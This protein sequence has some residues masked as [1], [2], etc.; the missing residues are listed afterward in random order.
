MDSN[1]RESQVEIERDAVSVNQI[2][3][4]AMPVPSED[5]MQLDPEW[6]IAKAIEQKLPVRSLEQLLLMRERLKNELAREAYFSALSAFQ[7]ECPVISKT[8][9]VIDKDGRTVRYRY[10][11]LGEIIRIVGPIMAHHGLSFS[12]DAAFEADPPAQVVTCT[13]HH[14]LGHSETSTFR[15]PIDMEA[16]MNLIQKSGSSLTYGK[17]YALSNALGIVA[18]EDDDG[19]SGNSGNSGNGIRRLETSG[20]AES[21]LLEA[22]KRCVDKC[23]D[24]NHVKNWA[25]KYTDLAHLLSDEK[26]AVLKSYCVDRLK[27]LTPK[28]VPSQDAGSIQL[29]APELS[30]EEILRLA[31]ETACQ[32]ERELVEDLVRTTPAL[33]EPERLQVEQAL[34]MNQ[35]SW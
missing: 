17:R 12:F 23:R 24:A 34:D 6:L 22:L 13:V 35:R 15:A 21:D 28:P 16:R 14:T 27:R 25:K 30:F 7:A 19:N 2:A 3:T 8:E 11:P 33:T 32:E 29:K 9:P 10:A 18:D 20:I 4:P 5:R 31:K 1:T 26:R